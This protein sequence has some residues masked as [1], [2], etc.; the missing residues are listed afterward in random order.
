MKRQHS[1]RPRGGRGSLLTAGLALLSLAVFVP[2]SFAAGLG[3]GRSSAGEPTNASPPSISGTPRQ[4]QILRAGTGTWHGSPALHFTFQWSACDDMGN[5]CTPITGATDRIYVP[6]TS[7]GTV[8]ATVTAAN[9]AG[10]TAAASAPTTPILSALPGAPVAT[11]Q[12]SI[13][14]RLV[15]GSTLTA[16]HGTWTGN[17]TR[18]SYRWRRCTAPDGP[19]DWFATTS[20]SRLRVTSALAGDALRVVVVA[21]D[22]VATSYA[23]S[24]ATGSV[25]PAA[26][27]APSLPSNVTAPAISGQAR[28]G[29]TLHAEHGRW[30]GARPVQFRYAWFRC[31]SQGQNCFRIAG[32]GSYRV[33]QADVGHRLRL[34]VVTSNRFGSAQAFSGATV[35]VQA[36]P[37]PAARL[38]RNTSRPTITGMAQQGQLLTASTG[39]WTSAAPMTFY[40]QWARCDSQGHNCSPV[41]GSLTQPTYTVTSGDVAH[42][43]IVQVKA[44]SST[45]DGFA[46]SAPTGLVTPLGSPPPQSVTSSAV[47]IGSV[48]LPDRLVVD[49]VQ[50]VPGV[51]TSRQA[52]LVVRVHVSELDHGKSVD[53]ALVLGLAVPFNRL[54]AEPE[55][56]TGSDGWAT[57]TYQ[58][59][60]TFELRRGNL[61]VLFLRARKPGENLLA[62]V[63][64]RRLVAVPVA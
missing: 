22:P 56:T 42:R 50:F 44:H 41:T 51:V 58:V 37:A 16:D 28:V 45:G 34:E 5:A 13:S 3:S 33:V 59:L 6:Q 55:A 27:R 48:S 14:G 8:T 19:C 52:P 35:V 57:I 9:S 61:I 24:A 64:T 21:R 31:D 46:D 23:E 30:N 39:T 18:I 38:P 54:S 7:G 11:S 25:S 36:S 12:P 43:L 2:L 47:S 10:S 40:Y 17:P 20:S 63:S 60:P 62:G 29:S 15:A 49:R 4:G 53:G 26:P 32:S 1:P